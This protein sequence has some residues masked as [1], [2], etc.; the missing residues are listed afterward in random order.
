MFK[1]IGFDID[2][3]LQNYVDFAS[4][5]FFDIHKKM[6]GKPYTGRIN[7]NGYELKDIFV[8][9]EHE[10]I[11]DRVNKEITLSFE[12]REFYP[13]AIA[14][15]RELKKR[16]FEIHLVT[17]RFGKTD[18]MMEMVKRTT[19]ACFDNNHCPYDEIHFTTDGDKVAI[20]KGS[21][22]EL[23]VE[24]AVHNI[25]PLSDAIPVIVISQPYN[26]LCRGANIYRLDSLE[27][28]TFIKTLNFIDKRRNYKGQSDKVQD[29]N[30][31]DVYFSENSCIVNKHELESSPTKPI[32]VIPLAGKNGETMLNKYKSTGAFRIF[33]LDQIDKSPEEIEDEI[34]RP[35]VAKYNDK[36]LD[37]S[38]T[39]EMNAEIYQVR[40]KI[41]EAILAKSKEL[42]NRCL[43]YGAQLMSVERDVMMKYKDC[44]FIFAGVGDAAKE[45]IMN[46][47]HKKDYNVVLLIEDID[48]VSMNIRKYKIIK[49]TD[50]K[51]LDGYVNRQYLSSDGIDVVQLLQN[52][53][54]YKPENLA[55]ILSMDTLLV[56]D[57][58]ISP[59][60]KEKTKMIIRN[61]N[62]RAGRDDHLLFL[63]DFDGK[64]GASKEDTARFLHNLN[65]KNIYLILG[66]N[67]GYKIEDYVA[68]GFKTVVDGAQF[69]NPDGRNI[70]F[71][72]CP[73]I[74]DNDDINIH[75]HLHGARCYWNMDWR[76]H[77]DV[78]DEQ[79]YPISVREC[80]DIVEKDLYKAESVNVLYY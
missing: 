32:F 67:D 35:I 59:N 17:S 20:I 24:D 64:R 65:C 77:Y 75:G 1:K 33:E 21:G 53:K 12:S 66:N 46:S 78:W 18:E 69:T 19:K 80:I 63:G 37:L 49:G 14:L 50:E 42:R 74:V 26:Q 55:A 6:Y 29:E 48:E 40:C 76:N 68:M 7:P 52:E 60:D 72:H 13:W 71:S 51:H 45:I 3:T 73:V 41:I 11:Y 10:E 4:D 38:V 44:P 39:N 36:K 31:F 43:F 58:H 2:G 62:S 9:C 8:D 27:P 30:A 28:D 22:I 70:I 25:L 56:S 34:I 23:M 16:K 79:F 5:L 47:I 15:L 57:C 61:I 54:P